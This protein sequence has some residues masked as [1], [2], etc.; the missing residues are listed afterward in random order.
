MLSHTAKYVPALGI[1]RPA[2]EDLV[3]GKHISVIDQYH[4]LLQHKVLEREQINSSPKTLT[5]RGDVVSNVTCMSNTS[6]TY[7]AMHAEPYC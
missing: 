1:L 6:L 2:Y 5:L 3:A 4:S 7:Y